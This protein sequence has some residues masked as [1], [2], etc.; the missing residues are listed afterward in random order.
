MNAGLIYNQLKYE[1]LAKRRR[2]CC[3]LVISISIFCEATT[4]CVCLNN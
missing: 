4:L 1:L 2:A 3:G